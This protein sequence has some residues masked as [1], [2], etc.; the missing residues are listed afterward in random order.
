MSASRIIMPGLLYIWVP[1]FKIVEPKR[2]LK[3]L[4]QVEGWWRLCV[5][6]PDGR[7]RKDTGWFPNIIT[8][9]GLNQIGT[10]STYMSVCRVGTGSATPTALDTGL[11]AQVASTSSIQSS[12][13]A[14][15][16][17]EPYYGSLTRTWRFAAGVAT[18]N[19]TEIGVGFDAGGN[20]FS[21]ALILD[22]SGNPTTITVLADEFLDATY[23]LRLK[24][25][26]VDVN[27][28]INIS[29]TDY[30][31]IT[32]AARVTNSTSWGSPST[33]GGSNT[34]NFE[35]YTGN[36]AAI[37]T[38]PTGQHYFTV[39]GSLAY[40]DGNLYRD[41]QVTVSLD[42]GNHVS[43]TRTIGYKLGQGG[44]MGHMQTQFDPVIMK[45]DTQVLTMTMRHTWAR[46]TP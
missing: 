22:G 43:G 20:I 5:R 26:L 9:V 33:G 44:A 16:G 17:S 6:R 10:L 39:A 32:R 31:T 3:S 38:L 21:R 45:N 42:N 41:F 40:G 29:G 36:I 25:P 46:G 8:D 13:N 35:M 11:G 4:T 34:F 7:V 23:Q 14:A 19:L 37:T 15:Q 27:S 24:P 18:G 30:D 28:S 12:I 2:L 1:K